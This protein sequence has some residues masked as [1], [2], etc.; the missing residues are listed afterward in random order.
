MYV[1]KMRYFP[2]LSRFFPLSSD[3]MNISLIITW[4]LNLEVLS[5]IKCIEF[6]YTHGS[7]FAACRSSSFLHHHSSSCSWLVVVII[8]SSLSFSLFLWLSQ[9]SLFALQYFLYLLYSFFLVF[10]D[11]VPCLGL[12]VLSVCLGLVW[13]SVFSNS[14][15][16]WSWVVNG[17]TGITNQCCRTGYLLNLKRPWLCR[18]ILHTQQILLFAN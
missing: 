1:V 3:N 12:L 2:F 17:V 15:C 4:T 8:L 14:V 5:S 6:R 11:S 18:V 13:V 16:V 7:G 9:S 10:R